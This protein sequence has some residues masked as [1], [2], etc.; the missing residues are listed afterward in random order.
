MSHTPYSEV[1]SN[2][3]INNGEDE[4]TTLTLADEENSIYTLISSVLVYGEEF[5]IYID[6]IDDEKNFFA[7]LIH[8]DSI[9]NEENT[10][11]FNK[12]LQSLEEEGYTALKASFNTPLLFDYIAGI[13]KTSF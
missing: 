9:D 5:L 4:K 3:E 7:N 8:Y 12:L 2:I 10:P 13:A 1:V 11:L 6:V